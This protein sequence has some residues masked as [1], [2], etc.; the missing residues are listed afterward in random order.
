[1]DCRTGRCKNNIQYVYRPSSQ[2]KCTKSTSFLTRKERSGLSTLGFR[3]WSIHLSNLLTDHFSN[4]LS[5]KTTNDIHM[6]FLQCHFKTTFYWL[7]L[8]NREIYLEIIHVRQN[9]IFMF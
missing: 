9:A 3:R 8:P 4:S 2:A 7:P 6:K 5:E 1:M